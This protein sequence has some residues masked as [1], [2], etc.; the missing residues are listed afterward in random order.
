MSAAKYR[1]KTINGSESCLLYDRFNSSPFQCFKVNLAKQNACFC[2]FLLWPSW[3][4]VYIDL[5]PATEKRILAVEKPQEK[6]P[7]V[8]ARFA[9]RLRR[10]QFLTDLGCSLRPLA[11]CGIYNLKTH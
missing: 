5:K 7:A 9:C 8:G 4:F 1:P 2:H 11:P 10:L 3:D 6:A